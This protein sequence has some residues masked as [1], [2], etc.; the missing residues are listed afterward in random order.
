MENPLFS[1]G[2]YSGSKTLVDGT[3]PAGDKLYAAHINELREAINNLSVFNVK[4]YGA[5][6]DG[7]TDD[8]AA[9]NDCIAA[10]SATGRFISVFFPA[11]STYLIS[12]TI[13]VPNTVAIIG[14]DKAST[15]IKTNLNIPMLKYDL[16]I[17]GSYYFNEIRGLTFSGQNIVGTKTSNVAILIVGTG[18]DYFSHI[19][20]HDLRFYITY[21]AIHVI[22]T[23]NV[24]GE[25]HHDWNNYHDLDIMC[26]GYGIKLDYG[27]GTGCH[28]FNVR[29]DCG[30]SCLEIGGS[31]DVNCGDVLISGWHTATAINAIKI[32]GPATA[33]N[34]RFTI[35]NCQ[36]DAG[37][38]HAVDFDN[39]GR[40]KIM[41]INLAGAP[42]DYVLTNC[43]NYTIEHTDY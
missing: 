4:D 37:V 39:I 22:K 9:I 18:N 42:T 20:I 6:G 2:D 29:A 12:D 35:L 3:P 1:P 25:N 8:T 14:A 10:A 32:R 21:T 28:Y 19:D 16:D 40:F 23:T 24:G 7:I 11:N 30:I 33:Y 36:F 17:Y 13:E 41:C 31:G 15:W 26:N 34:E 43:A 27:T 5:V 38:V